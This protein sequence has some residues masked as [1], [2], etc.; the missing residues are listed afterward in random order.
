MYRDPKD[1]RGRADFEVIRDPSAAK[2]PP[3]G[4]S[5]VVVASAADVKEVP[6]PRGLGSLENLIVPGAGRTMSL[7]LLDLADGAELQGKGAPFT[8]VLYFLSGTGTLK[9]A[10]ETLPLAAESMVYLPHG[11]PYAIKVAP[12]E[13]GEKIV[14]VQF[15]ATGPAQVRA[16]PAARVPGR[17]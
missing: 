4:P 12:A 7:A 13:K 17:K 1:A 9:V 3:A 16:V 8:E 10:G 6:L 14:V 15:K 2:A 11:T 5:G